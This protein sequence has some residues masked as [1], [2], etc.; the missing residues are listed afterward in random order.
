MAVKKKEGQ[1]QQEAAKVAG[2]TVAKTVA[3]KPAAKKP[4]AKVSAKAPVEVTATKAPPAKRTRKPSAKKPYVYVGKPE[5]DEN[6]PLHEQC[7]ILPQV[8]LFC[9]YYLTHYNATQAL[10]DAKYTAKNRN[11]ARVDAFH[12]MQKPGVRKYIALRTKAILS[13][14]EEEQDQLMRTFTEV[15]YADPNDLVEH[16]VD[17]CRFCYGTKHQYQFTPQEFE[18]YRE[19]HALNVSEAKAA[20]QPEPDFDPKGG[21][22]FNPNNEP[23]PDCPEC[24]GR[25][26]SITVIK[27]TRFLSPASL[28][29]YAGIKETK[30]GIEVKMHDQGK[31]RETLAKI[32]KLYDDNATVNVS[33][34]AADLED[35][36]GDKM[37]KAHERMARM[38][39]ERFGTKG[40]G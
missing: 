6:S 18:R 10:I 37:R 26:N 4:A 34:D 39:E 2:K 11:V 12:M 1:V 13:R 19:Q 29:L 27:D 3:K 8:A 20:G 21:A 17:C 31:A 40:E 33:F 16:R 36:F 35:K 32:R 38:R 15:A 14:L 22:G 30:D 28:R 5:P 7:G 23:E 25:G 9:D 24:F